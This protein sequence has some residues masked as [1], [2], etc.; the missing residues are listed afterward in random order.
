[1]KRIATLALAAAAA[2]GAHAQS[3]VTLFG[4]VDAN[5]RHVKNGSQTVKSLSNNGL[6]SSRLGF[7]GSEDL[8]GGLRASFWLEHGFNIDTGTQTDA[9]RFW[10]RRSTVSLSGGFG[11]LRLGRDF[12]PFYIGYA[13]FDVFGDNGIAAAGKFSDR[14][15]SNADTLTRAD[16][17]VSYFLPAMGGL[18]GQLSVSAGEGT[19]GKKSG[20]ARIGYNAGPLNVSLAYGR[21]EVTPIAGFDEH[22][23][24]ATGASYNFGPVRLSGYFLRDEFANAKLDTVSIGAA[25]PLGNGTIR[26]AYT[27]ANAKGR[28]AAGVAIDGNDADQVALGYVHALSK[29]TAIYATFARVDNDG[30]AAY[31]VA[32]SPTPVA[33]AKS[34]GYE[35]GLRHTF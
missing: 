3:T 6:N 34:T 33:G 32:T 14:L 1:M 7:R 24:I 30:A 16:N 29:R 21:T 15:G 19:G 17:Q 27:R 18:Y 22:E 31:A 4:V 2:A 20:G 9:S 35:L 5:V 25:V 10:N 8:G 13:D 12:T 28:N 26:A 23:V 11:E